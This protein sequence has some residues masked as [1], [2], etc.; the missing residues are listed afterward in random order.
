MNVV[1]LVGNGCS[2]TYNAAFK[3][4]T[5]TELIL[6]SLAPEAGQVGDVRAALQDLAQAANREEDARIEF[7]EDLFGPLDRLG[8]A[9][10]SMGRLAGLL[11]ADS[12]LGASL[13]SAFEMTQALRRA[14]VGTALRVV[15]DLSTGQGEVAFQP[16]VRLVERLVQEAGPAGA[17]NI[18]TLNYDALIDGAAL[19]ALDPKDISDMALGFGEEGIEIAADTWITAFR[20]R[21]DDGFQRPTTIHHLHG[22][23]Q[24]VRR[25]DEFWKVADLDDL[26]N[27]QFWNAYTTGHALVEPLVILT[28]QKTRAMEAEPFA[29]A[30]ADF[31]DSLRTADRV[32]IAGYGFGDVPVNRYLKSS[33]SKTTSPV[34]CIDVAPDPAE[35]VDRVANAIGLKRDRIIPYTNGLAEAVDQ[36]DWD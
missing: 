10:E 26:R 11:R 12:N 1:A 13:R 24:W 15:A 27:A 28:D 33:L 23:L 4:A 30:Y 2:I 19:K 32:L 35:L 22:S 34:V 16:Q 17:V 3:M 5:L 9:L 6:R 14:T 20:L 18:F 36:L 25:G 21:E 29:S 7:F 31:R 8:R